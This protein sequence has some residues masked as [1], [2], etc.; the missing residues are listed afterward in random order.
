MKRE[1][2]LTTLKNGELFDLLVIGG[3][4]TGCGVALD[5]ASR[6]LRVALVEKGD[7]ACGTSS[8]STK[9][10]HGGVRYLE[11]A[12][13][14][15]DRVQ[16]NLVRDGLKERAI[17]LRLAPH[18]CRRIALVT[19]LYER[20]EVPYVYSGLKLYDLLAGKDGVGHSQLLGKD[21]ALARFP[22][23]RG[24]GLKGAVL[25]YDGQFND[26]RMNLALALT[27]IDHG[28][29]AANHM[30]VVE[31]IREKGRIAGGMV[32]D[33][34]GGESW[35]V[36]A[37]CVV[38]ATG[39]FA[40]RVRLLD[41]PA[42]LPILSVSSGVHLVLDQRFTPPEAGI[43]IPRTED[44]RVLFVLPW[45]GRCLVGTTDHPAEL[46]E[47]PGVSEEEIAYLLR[48]LERY[49]ALKVETSD[50][51]ARW[52]GLRPLVHD[53]RKSDTARLARDHVINVSPSGLITISGGKWT[54]YRKMAEDTVNCAIARTGLTPRQGCRTEQI[55]LHGAQGF[56]PD[57]AALLEKEF[58]LEPATA[59]HLNEAYGDRGEAVANLCRGE[60]GEPLVAGFPYL[61]GEVRYA[62]IHEMA[63]SAADFLVRRIPLAL[64]DKRGAQAAAATVLALMAEELCWDRD[65]LA[66][67][68]EE[69]SVRLN[70]TI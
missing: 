3:G 50:I 58:G 35:P 59:A 64:L 32:R 2:Q 4:A 60:M 44:G 17:L 15:L 16:F 18:L 56:R 14:H 11:A 47:H 40:D 20:G 49:F 28:A 45:Q 57:G 65:R 67:E 48:H 61:K 38:N 34:F 23:I 5:A 8:R 33:P 62:I 46:S 54:T 36:R 39:P 55:L 19:P 9:L 29:A 68:S 43:T 70:G 42:A 30:E 69:I 52:S 51:A 21:E 31:L 6:G 24:E 1:D 12:V 27:A 26:A 53:P 25:Y 66:R 41:D 37:R 7:F 10:V 22:L 63:V 13:R